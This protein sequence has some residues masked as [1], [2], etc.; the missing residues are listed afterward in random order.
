MPKIKESVSE[1][2]SIE[3]YDVKQVAEILKITPRTVMN[4]IQ[5]G[6]LKG[7][8]I[9]GKWKFTREAIEAYVRGE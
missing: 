9:G 5:Q 1:V 2:F 6:K 8:K 7:R 3:L 4:Y